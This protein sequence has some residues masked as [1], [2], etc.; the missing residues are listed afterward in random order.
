M[1]L[2]GIA[3]MFVGPGLQ[4]IQ[5]AALQWDEFQ[6]E[7][8]RSAG[9]VHLAMPGIVNLRNPEQSQ[10]LLSDNA[11]EPSHTVLVPQDIESSPLKAALA[12]L[13]ACDFTGTNPSAFERNTRFINEFL[14]AGVGSVVASLWRVGDL[15]AAQFMRHFYQQL[16]NT[17]N[18]GMALFETKQMYLARNEASDN[19]AWAAFQLFTR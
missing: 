12:V 5:G 7:R 9:I 18:A 15:Q 14:Q 10:L 3:D 8:F 13:S 4:I 19:E 11:D 16:V 17:Q 2:D 6:D 1:E